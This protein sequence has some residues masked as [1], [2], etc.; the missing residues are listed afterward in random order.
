MENSENARVS[1]LARQ[2]R[3]LST[4]IIGGNIK[5]IGN[6]IGVKMSTVK[7]GTGGL[8]WYAHVSELIRQQSCK[9]KN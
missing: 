4:T 1:F 6:V 7:T 5:I 9:L 8:L 3:N 2:C